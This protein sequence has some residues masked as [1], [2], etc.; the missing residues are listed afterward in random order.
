VSIQSS[1]LPGGAAG[2]DDF[3]DV[4]RG[5]TGEKTEVARG[6]KNGF[7]ST[8]GRA[9]QERRLFQTVKLFRE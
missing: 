7:W 6:N 3:P 2:G 1:G 8:V 9:G 5:G 4:F